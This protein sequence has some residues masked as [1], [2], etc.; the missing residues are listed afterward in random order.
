MR[1]EREQWMKILISGAGGKLGSEL[2]PYF[3][4]LGYEVI[5]LDRSAWDV[6]NQQRTQQIISG[7][8]P[9]VLI[10]CAAYTN[11]D[12]CESNRE[13]AEEIH[14]VATCQIAKCCQDYGVRMVY[15]ST[16]HVFQ[17]TKRSG[18]IES[19]QTSPMNHYGRT[20]RQGELAVE[21]FCS[22]GLILRTSWLYGHVGSNFVTSIW[23]S[24]E[25]G[26][27]LR[28]VQD[29]F[30]SPTYAVDFADCLHSLLQE[31]EAKGIYHVSGSGVCS[32]YE[33]AHAILQQAKINDRLQAIS[34]E[35]MANNKIRPVY[36]VLVS[37]RNIQLPDWSDGLNRFFERE[38]K[39]N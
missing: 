12:C 36:S 8:K 3:R 19:D 32:W 16:N 29:H 7:I 37:E 13:V 30:G 25:Q 14:S 27:V 35:E 39:S 1:E 22:N 24:A 28:V 2:T 31:E 5:A 18:Y 20:K 33:F 38:A 34:S 4:I 11:I 9:D 6:T 26:A 23:K 10:H 15:I 17:G 21:E